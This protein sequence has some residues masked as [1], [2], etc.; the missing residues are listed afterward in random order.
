MKENPTN[1]FCSEEVFLDIAS[2]IIKASDHH[3]LLI[4]LTLDN[5]KEVTVSYGY[6]AGNMLLHDLTVFFQSHTIFLSCRRDT[7]RLL[8]L[9]D[10]KGLEASILTSS[11][12]KQYH[13]FIEYARKQY[14]LSRIGY[15]AGMYMIPLQCKDILDA[16]RKADMAEAYIHSS[17]SRHI[18]F[19]DEDIYQQQMF[20]QSILPLFDYVAEEKRILLYLQP[21]MSLQ[22]KQLIGAE[23][24]VRIR[25]QSGSI[26]EP[27]AFIPV[28]EKN[29]LIYQLDLMVLEQTLKLLSEWLEKGLNPVP[30]SI[31]LSKLDFYSPEFL[32]IVNETLEQYHIPKKYLEFE[33]TETCF[34]DEF[35]VIAEHINMLHAQGYTFTID[36]FGRN[37]TSLINMG[38]L[39]VDVVKL[40]HNLIQRNI[41]NPKGRSILTKLI[42]MFSE[43]GLQTICEGIETE[44]EA[45]LLGKCGCSMVQ[46]Y[47]YDKP[48]PVDYFYKKYIEYRSNDM[49]YI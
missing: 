40:D 35:E 26:L 38:L 32:K 4:S 37:D 17:E 3:C 45:M 23:V 31:N 14:P 41:K 30:L 16:V 34:K 39:P 33:M 47:L 22:T 24:L 27:A 29:G 5:Y 6:H 11:L 15:H 13:D 28:L 46:G 20:E 7:D 18:V 12:E 1:G 48:L 8:F 9:M 49:L 42:E 19:Y 10:T 44:E 21:K 25:S 36:H 2:D 43:I